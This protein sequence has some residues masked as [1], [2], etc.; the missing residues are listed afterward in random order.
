[1]RLERQLR[2]TNNDMSL[3]A[4]LAEGS[5]EEAILSILLE[6]DAIKYSKENLLQQR[7]IRSRS[8]KRFAAKYLNKGFDSKIKII[9]VHDS[10]QENFNLP[11]AYKRQ[12]SKVVD[13]YTRPEIEIL[14][15]LFHDDY[16]RF[17]NWHPKTGNAKPS[18]YVKEH[19]KDLENIKSRQENIDFW[20]RHFDSLIK[21]L[22]DYKSI[23]HPKGEKCIADLLVV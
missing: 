10:L 20:N 23:R 17:K 8:A 14:Y 16:Q 9:R 4:L 22:K 13:L 5:A 6:H 15:I 21:V 19:Y 3:V 12:V 11:P 18:I 2:M 1:M 7:I